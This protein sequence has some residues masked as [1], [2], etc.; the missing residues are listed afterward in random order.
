MTFDTSQDLRLFFTD[1]GVDITLWPGEARQRTIQR[2][3]LP[4]REFYLAEAGGDFHQSR[5]ATLATFASNPQ[6]Q[7]LTSDV[8]ELA[9]GDLLRIHATPRLAEA[10]GLFRVVSNQPDGRGLS[11]LE[12]HQEPEP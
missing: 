3:C 10:G 12:L 9:Q 7:C 5:A 11:L 8:A 6:A 4:R 2:G 1:F